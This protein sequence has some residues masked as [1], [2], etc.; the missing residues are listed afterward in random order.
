MNKAK[1]AREV[2]LAARWMLKHVGWQQ[3]QYVS[4]D[5]DVNF[6]PVA[7]CAIGA[8]MRVEKENPEDYSRA[9]NELFLHIGCR[10][11][12]WNDTP[13]RTKEEVLAAFDQAIER[14]SK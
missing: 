2:L 7:F 11:P 14:I 1:N 13:G 9:L 5:V 10:I 12:T 6:K 3:G 8:L 4:Y